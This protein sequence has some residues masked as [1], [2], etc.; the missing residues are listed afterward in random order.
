LV[1]SFTDET[2]PKFSEAGE[3]AF[4]KAVTQQQDKGA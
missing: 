2:K 4:W 3:E 1:T